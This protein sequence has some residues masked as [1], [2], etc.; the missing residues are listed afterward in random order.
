M[1]RSIR[2]CTLAIGTLLAAARALTAQPAE[3]PPARGFHAHAF[4]LGSI[5]TD[6]D[7]PHVAGGGL[8]QLGYG[9]ASLLGV[10]TIGRGGDYESVLV[11]GALALRIATVGRVALSGFGGYGLYREEGW[12]GIERDAGGILFGALA[13]VRLGRATVAFALSDLAGEY[14]EDDIA[15]P[16]RFHVPRFS[17]GLGF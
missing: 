11:G 1:T 17:I 5:T 2:C 8:V 14:G 10:G 16:F 6:V 7:R 12:S 3:A 13:A 4:A 15:E 9:R